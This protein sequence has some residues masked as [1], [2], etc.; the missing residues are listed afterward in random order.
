M[1]NTTLEHGYEH[2]IGAKLHDYDYNDSF[3]KEDIGRCV[4]ECIDSLYT[5]SLDKQRAACGIRRVGGMMS[6][7]VCD[8]KANG[9]Y[10]FSAS[11]YVLKFP[12]KNVF[13]FNSLFMSRLHRHS[14]G[15][16]RS[17]SS[18]SANNINSAKHRNFVNISE[19]YKTPF[20]LGPKSNGLIHVTDAKYIPEFPGK[21]VTT[22]PPP[23]YDDHNIMFNITDTAN[24]P[25]IFSHRLLFF[26]D[27]KMFTDLMMYVVPDYI[28][29]VI[30]AERNGVTLPQIYEYTKPYKDYRWSLIGIP[31]GNCYTT[32][33]VGSNLVLDE[34]GIHIGTS[35]QETDSGNIVSSSYTV[36][37]LLMSRAHYSDPI[38]SRFLVGYAA[39]MQRTKLNKLPIR[40]KYAL[41]RLSVNGVTSV[42]STETTGSH[43]SVT[44]QYYI[45]CFN[46][47]SINLG[48]DS[49]TKFNAS[50]AKD[51]QFIELKNLASIIKLKY[52]R[53]FQVGCDDNIPGPVPAENILIFKEVEGNGLELVHMVSSEYRDNKNREPGE[54]D[55]KVKRM[56]KPL[57]KSIG[58]TSYD[59]GSV[60]DYPKFIPT[61]D[62]YEQGDDIS[63]TFDTIVYTETV[64]S[65][66]Y[67][68]T[69]GAPG[70]DTVD[71]VRQ[72]QKYINSYFP[73]VFQLE[74]F[75]ST[76]NLVAFVFYDKSCE[77]KFDN[78]LDS[79]L[80]FDTIYANNVVMGNLPKVIADYIPIVDKY[81]EDMYL[82]SYHTKAARAIEHQYKLEALREFINDDFSRLNGIYDKRY[83][84]VNNKLHSNVKYVIDMSKDS[85]SAPDTKY[86]IRR[87]YRD[88]LEE[89]Y[90][91]TKHKRITDVYINVPGQQNPIVRSV[92]SITTYKADSRDLIDLMAPAL[93][94]DPIYDVTGTYA[95]YAPATFDQMDETKVE[96]TLTT[97][98]YTRNT[99]YKLTMHHK[100]KME[101]S[102]SIWINGVRLPDD[103]YFI[104]H[105]VFKSSISILTSAIPNNAMIELE[106]YKMKD[107]D[108]RYT[109]VQLPGI[110]N[111]VAISGGQD[112]WKD[113]SP[114]N[115]MVAIE[116]L[117]MDDQGRE[118]L[119]YLVPSS[120]ESYWLLIGHT[121]YTDG[122]PVNIPLDERE[123]ARVY[124]FNV[125][126]SNAATVNTGS[127]S[128]DENEV[129]ILADE[130][131]ALIGETEQVFDGNVDILK[132]FGDKQYYKSYRDDTP[133]FVFLAQNEEQ[134]NL[135]CQVIRNE[136][137][138]DAE[139]AEY[140][141]LADNPDRTAEEEARY[142]EL[143]DKKTDYETNGLDPVDQ[144]L[145]DVYKNLLESQLI[146]P[147]DHH[148]YVTMLRE[149]FYG[150]DRKRFFD[151]L[152]TGKNDP[153]VFI[154]PITPFFANET[155]M[156]KNT[157]VY[158][159]KT[160]V[161]TMDDSQPTSKH[162]LIEKFGF[163]PSMYKYRLFMDGKLLDYDYDYIA[164]VNLEDQNFFTDSTLDLYIRRSVGT[165]ATHTFVLEYLPYKYQMI[166]RSAEFDGVITLMDEYLRPFD[167]RHYDVYVDGVLLNEDE[168]TIVTERRIIINSIA[169]AVAA[170]PYTTYHPIVSIYER[171]HDDDLFD[172][173]W[174][175][176][177]VSFNYIDHTTPTIDDPDHPGQKL[178]NEKRQPP[179]EG[180]YMQV[181]HA[182]RIKY[183]LDEQLIRTVENYR[184]IK[185]P[186]YDPVRT[187]RE[188]PIGFDYNDSEE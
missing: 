88:Q 112:I 98:E 141:E 126:K 85:T 90:Q 8:S 97:T 130:N 6:D 57:E 11:S 36:D 107:K 64:D 1:V 157:D 74:G 79:Y 10:G 142:T 91:T 41:M 52:N 61:R 119:R 83:N 43:E 154:T 110:H 19:V 78:P 71:T 168:I 86:N 147:S 84:K 40:Q 159:N 68:S 105:S 152:P 53:I 151:Y 49:L 17:I 186:T 113:I 45:D 138:T 118:K 125:I 48:S 115:V 178:D 177:P 14:G 60:Y 93:D 124:D 63:G 143:S 163:D 131:V 109:I 28:I 162:V 172:Y 62:K 38:N 166:H 51:M 67:V 127:E 123:V 47:N 66:G 27:G 140:I 164:M 106:V 26:M 188:T 134:Y 69:T 100:E 182:K 46:Q 80:E 183:S 171:M 70:T 59:R 176:E 92:N 187:N 82:N 56:E 7:F 3:D 161:I 184:K 87:F 18:A 121:Q 25:D 24:R 15:Y 55:A 20:G 9:F 96:V 37:P 153:K 13:Y 132:T 185:T 175:K 145:Y 44:K 111:S 181:K 99:S 29:M 72:T 173:V 149:G 148:E 102:A 12:I 129:V 108:A 22:D 155:V 34:T 89:V 122:V 180:T 167:L 101:F 174:R 156:V 135:I 120:Y 2:R 128:I 165:N 146:D 179:E 136:G 5:T 76:D 144:H 21:N 50:T 104:S 4:Q 35:V 77:N 54:Y 75:E 30:D 117:T 150:R 73:N 116:K 139:N 23:T 16:K 95:R 32:P 160:N 137:L 158:F 65:E 103:K 133:V 114:Q 81:C 42:T 170:D 58:F 31:F 169:D 33:T 39:D 94:G